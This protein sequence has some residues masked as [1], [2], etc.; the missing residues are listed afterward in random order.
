MDAKSKPRGKLIAI[1]GKTKNVRAWC[2]HF[3]IS[4]ATYYF[5]LKR[6]WE[7]IEALTTPLEREPKIGT[8][9]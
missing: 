3:K 2:K 7:P 5:R 6:N 4:T 8:W 9:D 1:D